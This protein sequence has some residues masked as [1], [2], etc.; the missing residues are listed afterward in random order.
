[1][2]RRKRSRVARSVVEQQRFG[3][4]AVFEPHNSI[5]AACSN[6]IIRPAQ[7]GRGFQRK[8]FIPIFQ[9]LASEIYGDTYFHSFTPL[10]CEEFG[11]PLPPV[12]PCRTRNGATRWGLGTAR[13]AAHRRIKMGS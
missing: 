2:D 9:A 7:L 3:Q 13:A 11:Q 1:M 12:P 8:E 10:A 5:E 4:L 6:G